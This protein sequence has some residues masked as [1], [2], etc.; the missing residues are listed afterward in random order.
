MN[1]DSLQGDVGEAPPSAPEV[2]KINVQIPR[3][4]TNL[5]K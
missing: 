3:C 2:S 5:A 4:S 1:D